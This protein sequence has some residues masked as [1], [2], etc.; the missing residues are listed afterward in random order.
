MIRVYIALGSNLAQPLQQV[1]TALEA[2]EH[3][4]RTPSDRL[5]AAVPYQAAGATEPAGLS[6]RGGGT[7][8]PVATG[9]ATRSHPGDRT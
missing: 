7:G 3:I 8:Y 9:T 2:L 6:Q 5:F 4:P 1:N